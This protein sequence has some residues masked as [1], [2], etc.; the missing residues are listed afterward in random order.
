M[1][2]LTSGELCE[3][4]AGALGVSFE[5]TREHLRNIRRV[6]EISFTG[7][8]RGAAK[9]TT[10]DASRL[11]IAVAGS[12][13][14]KDSV[15]SLNEFRKLQPIG[16]GKPT[17]GSLTRDLKPK[18]AFDV[19]VAQMMQRLIDERDRLSN[20]YRRPP[21]TPPPSAC[22]ALSLISVVS[23]QPSDFPRAAIARYFTDR[24]VS[25]LSFASPKWSAP[26]LSE[27][28]FAL[29]VRGVGLMQTR[30]VPAWALAD[31]ALAL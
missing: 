4:V 30:H 19:Y 2:V 16:A 7:Y 5:T 13:F 22:F 18:I 12:S 29:N 1:L 8:G 20:A 3:A 21:Q 28:E 10:L 26:M 6:G 27:V 9:M 17:P 25:A 23:A 15:E 11:L 24:G 31:I 14:A